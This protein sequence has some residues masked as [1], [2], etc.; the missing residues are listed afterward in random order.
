MSTG[1]IVIKL[2]LDDKNFKGTISGAEG[3]VRRF[4][5]AVRSSSDAIEKDE[6]H[7]KTWA[8]T[9]RD[10]VIVL[11]LARHAIENV[12]AVLFTLPTAV[13]RANAEL[14]RMTALMVGL[15]TET[16][17]FAEAQLDA[18][19]NVEFLF[20]AAKRAPFEIGALTDAFVKMKAVGLDPLGG[21]FQGLVDSVAKFG[22]TTE[23]LK[24]ASIAIQQMAGKGVISMEELRQQLGEAVPDAIQIMA[25][26]MG[27]SMGE[28]VEKVSTGTVEAKNALAAMAR[29]MN[30]ENA[31]AALRMSETWDGLMNRLKTSITL[32]AKEIGDAG[33]FDAV[34]GQLSVIVND[35]LQDPRFMQFMKDV[36][37]SM[38][39]VTEGAVTLIGVMYEYREVIGF[40]TTAFISYLAV[41]TAMKHWD[42]LI[43]AKKALKAGLVAVGTEIVGVRNEY[44]RASKEAQLYNYAITQVEGNLKRKNATLI[45]LQTTMSRVTTAT[46]GLIA[47]VGGWSTVALVGVP[48]MIAGL[49]ALRDKTASLARDIDVNRPEFITAEQIQVIDDA[50]AKYDQLAAEIKE[51]EELQAKVSPDSPLAQN[52]SV[53]KMTKEQQQQE[54]AD[55]AEHGE[56]RQKALQAQ[57]IAEQSLIENTVKSFSRG[58]EVLVA[59]ELRQALNEYKSG[60]QELIDNQDEMT[61]EGFVQARK[62]QETRLA[63]A[64]KAQFDSL[65]AQEQAELEKQ[66]K[67]QGDEA[68][69]QVEIQRL[70]IEELKRLQA[71]GLKVFDGSIW[72]IKTLTDEDAEAEL[73]KLEQFLLSREKMLAKY[74]ARTEEE[75]PY[76]AEFEAMVELGQFA[77]STNEQIEK[78]RETMVEL[79]EARKAWD[80]QNAETKAFEDSLQRIDELTRQV[81]TKFEQRA[82]TNPLMRDTIEAEKLKGRLAEVALEIENLNTIDDKAK[83]DALRRLAELG[84]QVEANA[85]QATMEQ[86]KATT[87]SI[88][89]QLLPNMER[90]EAQYD[91]LIQKAYQWRMEQGELSTEE[92]EAFNAYL[93][94]INAKMAD[95]MKTPMDELMEQWSDNTAQM[96]NLWTNTMESF[97]DTLTNGLMEGKLELNSFVEEFARMVIKMQLQKAAAGIVS[98]LGS[99]LGGGT[100]APT[101]APY[102][103]AYG[104][105]NGGIMTSKGA[106][107]LKTYSNG[108]IANSPQ[109][110]LYGEGRQPEAYVPLPDGRTIPVTMETKGQGRG[111]AGMPVTVNMINESGQPMEA[112]NRGARFDGEQFV[113]DVVLKGL[114]RPG[115]FR[116]GV[117]TALTK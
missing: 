88:N 13:I 14:E 29:Q 73:T 1:Q 62:D 31:G 18:K 68:E 58:A 109:L 47:A 34:K 87:D 71:E 50:I 44:R 63:E 43:D 33:F 3:D 86:M 66:S 101:P 22:G 12:S 65:I 48:L 94:A 55:I 83:S 93:A 10:S 84:D 27:V 21:M 79:W 113:L 69:K 103:G 36:G 59:A 60:L 49:D 115:N 35:T 97:V 42:K 92:L 74:Q 67:M 38:A 70:K 104:F 7:H 8:R 6:R 56:N 81:N 4:E 64:I 99:F 19:K 98:G 57:I 9:L 37:E 77:K 108:G 72:E 85:R 24:R 112:E 89:T 102:T 54:L 40:V 11:G 45:T 51:V 107:A 41:A 23:Q 30:I 26:S 96:Q 106:M 82:N 111:A 5:R 52:L 2:E 80:A 25:R 39:A 32:A 76:L 61:K 28:L 95:E 16:G 116:S 17:G 110:A 75:N 91:D 105:A 15:S 90:I 20:E 114:N 53:K 100:P 117:K 78:A 46:K